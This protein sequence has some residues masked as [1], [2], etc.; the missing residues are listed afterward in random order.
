M[1]LIVVD[2]DVIC[3]GVLNG[4]ETL[5]AT[6]SHTGLKVRTGSAG[7]DLLTQFLRSTPRR[8]EIYSGLRRAVWPFPSTRRTMLPEK[9]MVERRCLW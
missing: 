5:K 9:V 2:F 4:I 3:G 1:L 6:R 8:V 7:K